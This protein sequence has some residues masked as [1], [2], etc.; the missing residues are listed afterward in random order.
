MIYFDE[1]SKKRLMKVLSCLNAGRDTCSF[2][3]AE[4]LF[5]L[6]QQIP[7]DPFRTMATLSAHP[8]GQLNFFPR[9]APPNFENS[10]LRARKI[11]IQELNEAGILLENDPGQHR[12]LCSRPAAHAHAQGRFPPPADFRELSELAHGPGS[13][14]D[15]RLWSS[16][17]AR[18]SPKSF[19]PPLNPSTRCSDLYRGITATRHQRASNPHS[20]NWLNAPDPRASRSPLHSRADW[21][22]KEKARI[23]EA[24]RGAETVYRLP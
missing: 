2:G 13:L 23:L 14:L 4:S 12:R 16:S 10:S 15:A 11:S 24:L 6:E 20:P 22:P 8:S 21:T 7:D 5:R 18:L 1:P 17:E 19:S 3:H 9:S